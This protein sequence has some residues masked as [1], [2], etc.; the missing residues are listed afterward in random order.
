MGSGEVAAP[1]AEWTDKKSTELVKAFRG[2][3]E[4]RVQT[5]NMFD[6]AYKYVYHAVTC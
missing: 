2:V 1:G 6:D 3:Q 4:E 5:Y